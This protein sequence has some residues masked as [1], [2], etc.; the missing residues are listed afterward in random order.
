MEETARKILDDNRRLQRAIASV[1]QSE[2]DLEEHDSE[3]KDVT[4]SLRDLREQMVR[5]FEHEE[6][7]G[8]FDDIVRRIPGAHAEVR[9]LESQHQGLLADLD[10]LAQGITGSDTD[11]DAL[12]QGLHRLIESFE[13]HESAENDLLHRAYDL[14]LGAGD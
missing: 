8:L 3:P 6:E 10:R 9:N 1:K 11:A 13:K 14:D 2:H 5:H 4:E 7:S 12:A